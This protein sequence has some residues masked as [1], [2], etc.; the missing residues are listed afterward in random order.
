M[1]SFFL[2]L[3]LIS[4]VTASSSQSSEETTVEDPATCAEQVREYR[5]CT[6][7]FHSHLSN[8]SI[9]HEVTVAYLAK[10]EQIRDEIN[11]LHC[12]ATCQ[13]LQR[14]VY[15]Y[16]QVRETINQ[17][18][19]VVTN[20]SN[21]DMLLEFEALRLALRVLCVRLDWRIRN[22]AHVAESPQ[23]TT[24]EL[25]KWPLWPIPVKDSSSIEDTEK[26]TETD[27]TESTEKTTTESGK[28]SFLHILGEDSQ[29]IEPE[30][31]STGTPEPL[32]DDDLMIFGE[33]PSQ[34]NGFHETEKRDDKHFF[35][36]GNILKKDEEIMTEGEWK[37]IIE[38]TPIVS[39]VA[40][41]GENVTEASPGLGKKIEI[42]YNGDHRA[43]FITAFALPALFFVFF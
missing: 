23:P 21:P 35:S 42:L 6:S 18:H 4:S 27:I 31:E 41:E 28:Y 9:I 10:V 32:D 3:V 30:E 15:L 33:I 40:E 24:T 7:S 36:P 20:R 5:K 43:S 17:I 2:F 26:S 37:D 1:K 25:N 19:L 13:A 34:I 39:D 29:T 11:N 22:D 12:E 38:E 16:D 8:F 14:D